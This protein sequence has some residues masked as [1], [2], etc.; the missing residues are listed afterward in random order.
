MLT[1]ILDYRN[2]EQKDIV[3]IDEIV[4]T[5]PIQ[6]STKIQYY[7]RCKSNDL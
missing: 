7:T 2:P 1:I 6:Q 3:A 5:I 4:T